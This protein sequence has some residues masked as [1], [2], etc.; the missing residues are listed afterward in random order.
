MASEHPYLVLVP[1]ACRADVR[2]YRTDLHRNVYRRQN[3]CATAES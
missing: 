3:L 1:R 2:N